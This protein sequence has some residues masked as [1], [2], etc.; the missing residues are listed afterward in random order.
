VGGSADRLRVC[1]AVELT[2][3]DAPEH[4]A[5]AAE[6]LPAEGFEVTVVCLGGRDAFRS[7]RLPSRGRL[8]RIRLGTR[9]RPWDDLVALYRLTELFA[10]IQPDVVHA[11]GARAGYL[12]RVAAKLCGIRRV[13]YTAHGFGFQRPGIP[14]WR[15]RLSLWAEQAAGSWTHRYV[16]HSSEDAV[17]AG[18]VVAPYKI[19]VVP[20]G[21]DLS[22]P[23]PPPA[24]RTGIWVGG[25]GGTDDEGFDTFRE[26]ARRIAPDVPDA[27]F[28]WIARGLEAPSTDDGSLPSGRFSVAVPTDWAGLCRELALADVFLAVGR[29]EAPPL[30]VLTVLGLGIPVVALSWSGLGSVIDPGTSGFLAEG[31]T[32]AEDYVRRLLSDAGLRRRVGDAARARMRRLHPGGSLPE[33][34]ARL[35]RA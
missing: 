29:W 18:Q 21:M 13:F 22:D 9:F 28:R 16:A 7:A 1:L 20:P 10:R 4:A 26:L 17:A 2:A 30:P 19:E 33:S 14:A 35:Y 15:R 23:P 8:E 25:W 24:D 32:Q 6:G 3:G 34:L 5:L 11:H 31:T 27:R 12:A